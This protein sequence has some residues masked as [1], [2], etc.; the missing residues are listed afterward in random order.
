MKPVARRTLLHAHDMFLAC[1]NGVYMDYQKN[2]ACTRVP[3]SLACIATHCAK[4][5]Y[6]QKLWRVVR[7]ARVHGA[8]GELSRW[9]GIIAIHPAMKA[10]LG[11]AGYRQDR[12]FTVR[13][14][15]VPFAPARIRAEE[16]A[17]LLYVGRLEADKG[18]GEVA[19]VASTVHREGLQATAIAD[20]R[21]VALTG[22]DELGSGDR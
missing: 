18:V 15:V 3:N 4:R 6:G 21:G 16:N 13:N 12:M 22:G 8:L 17:A 10:K 9:G 20:H 7:E 11:R 5:G 1:P 14:P 19:A 2:R